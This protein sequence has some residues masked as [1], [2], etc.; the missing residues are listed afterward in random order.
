[1]S[2][3]IRILETTQNNG[4]RPTM[5][6]FMDSVKSLFAGR[7]KLN[8]KEVDAI[9]SGK[10]HEEV[11]KYLAGTLDDPEWVK[12]NLPENE[13]G[14]SPSKIAFIQG[15][16]ESNPVK[17]LNSLD[18]AYRTAEHALSILSA[19]IKLRQEL[20][21]KLRSLRG[22]SAEDQADALYEAN[23]SK[24]IPN[25]S[26]YYL[27]HGGR[28]VPGIIGS[29]P[30]ANLKGW[31]VQV[32]ARGSFDFSGYFDDAPDNCVVDNPSQRTVKAYVSSIK[33]LT[34]IIARS[35]IVIEKNTIPYWEVL[36]LDYDELKYGD[37]IL[38]DI[39]VG[40]RDVPTDPMLYVRF[41]AIQ[42]LKDMLK[43][44]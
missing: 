2:K 22:P 21:K 44:I 9:L 12:K 23:R 17:L 16:N 25:V 13:A 3:F 36:P 32:T 27:K 26:E 28:D 37:Q 35:S 42:L 19:N 10:L 30:S 5:E 20:C 1:M 6:G 14:V 43:A 29:N 11:S 39:T 7:K 15:K 24:L 31:P 34:D 38:E 40:Q 41:C 8:E 4:P 18:T 33:A